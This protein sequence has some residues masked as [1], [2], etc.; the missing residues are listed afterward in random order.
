MIASTSLFSL[1]SA[2]SQARNPLKYLSVLEN[3]QIQTP[4]H[5]IHAFSQFDLTFDLHRASQHIRL[6]LEPNHDVLAENAHIEYVDKHGNIRHTEKVNREDY[7]VFQGKSWLQEKDGRYTNVGW[8][9]IVVR[10]DGIK[11]LFEGAFTLYGDN[12]HIQMKSNYMQTKHE[13]DPEIE[14]LDDE[15]LTVFRDSDV[16]RQSPRTELKRSAELACGADRLSFNSDLNHPVYQNMLKRDK[17]YWGSVDF[18]ALLGK[19]QSI[20]G[21]GAPGGGNSGGVNLKNTIGQTAGCPTTR[22]VALI[23]VATDCTYT[24]QFNA[25]DAVRQNVITQVNTASEL[26]QSTFNITLGLQNLTVSDAECPT[27]AST[28]VPWNIGC[29]SDNIEQR[30]NLFSQWR[31]QRPDNNAYW[32]LWSTCNTGAE[33]GLAWLGQLCNNAASSQ[34]DTSGSTQT[35]SGANVIIRTSNEWQVFAHETGHTFGAVHDCDSR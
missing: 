14:D 33:V 19:R 34:G 9:R 12:H 25:T 23:G 6:S 26:Y 18:A 32:S 5:R 11:P 27:T 35:V 29:N 8:A 15:Y 7:K 4:S 21:G 2:H 10:R 28:S 24:S 1:I 3:P 31:G 16:S 20:D 13:L 30:L 17:G 22:K